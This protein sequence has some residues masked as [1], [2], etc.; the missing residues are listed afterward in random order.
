MS[1]FKIPSMGLREPL[2]DQRA[3]QAPDLRLLIDSAPALIHTSLPDGYL[4]FFNQGWLDYVGRSL[5]DLLGWR[6]TDYIHPDDVE[7]IVQKWRASLASGEPFLH[8]TRVRRADGEYRWML[9]HKVAVRDEHG[10]IVKWHG[11][12]IDIEDRKRAEEAL[13]QS[14]FYLAE[15]QRLAH[16]GSWAFNAAGFEYWSPELFRIYGLDPS[17]KPPTVEEYLALVHPEDRAF[18]KQGITEML[19]DHRAFDFTKRIVRPDGEI[20]SVRCVGVPVTQGG[21]FH[22][23]LGTGMDVTE[24][25]QLTRELRRREAYLAEAQS[26]SHTGSFGWKPDS[27]EIVWSDETYRIF[28]YDP[29]V[30]ITIDSIAQR[31]HPEDRAEFQEV[32][33]HASAGATHFE[34][35]YRLLLPDGRI[36]HIHA[37]AHA[38]QDASGNREFVG[39]GIDVT[40]IKRAEEELRRSEAYLA[41]AQR[42]SKTGSWAWSPDQDIGYWSEECY[43]VLSFDPQDG[44]PRFEDFFQRIH[45]DD[46]PGFRELIQT[47]IREKA[48]WEADYRIVHLDGPVRDIHAV[49]HPVLSTSGH[50]IEFVGTVIDVTERKRAEEELRRSEMELRQMLDLAPQFVAVFGP[51]GERLY[52]NRIALD[53]VGLSLEEWRHCPPGELYHPDDREGVLRYFDRAL[54]SGS[55]HEL[56]VRLRKSDGNY[57]WF[58]ARYNPLRDEKGHITRWYAAGTDIE[59]RKLAE[60]RLRNENIALREEISNASMFEEIVGSSPPLRTVLSRIAKVAPT[61][62]TVLITGETGTGKELVA[63]AIHRRS[64]RCSRPFVS[65]NCAAI[66]R[67]L[68]ASELFGHEK[69]AFT[70]ALQ[71][72]V[73]KFELAEGGTIFLDE[74]GELPAE[75]Q[76]ALLRVLQEREFE[77]VGGNQAIR[78][79][80]RVIAATNRDL[81]S[82]ID[83]GAF[84]SDLFYRLNVFPIEV[85]PLRARREDIAML[86]EYFIDRFARQAGKKIKSIDKKTLELVEA[87]PW[88]GNIRELQNVIERS[89]VLSETETF[90]VDE[91]WLSRTSSSLQATS[92]TLSKTP[93]PEEKDIIEAALAETRGRVSGQAGAAA[94][95]GIPSTTLESKIKSLKINKHQFKVS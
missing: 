78:T 13:Q 95:L 94:K 84:R 31:V 43:R 18:M 2:D 93:A 68:I 10:N 66:P 29:T 75:T 81:Q 23:F 55:A 60:E 67:D 40:S 86:V 79:D 12:S 25:E 42:L 73:G 41:E 4:D 22:G 54:S 89:V 33:N 14:Q 1:T 35:A 15:G 19:V 72:R 28:E 30:R 9:H 38:L 34:H 57:R 8:E 47:A 37:L 44:L 11:S 24:Q 64:Q 58:L 82:A 50:L 91:S 20:R 49:G 59:E 39:A 51:G 80:A 74:V 65:V 71:R 45:P 56:E 46:Q 27:E 16:M 53:Y 32:I 26:L 90:S 77:R 17:G 61:G 21:T 63:R 48:E 85:P 87:Y 52:A 7:G 70:G 6:W 92:P 36:K 69:G 62:S 76:I 3:G 88:P 5:E 83:T